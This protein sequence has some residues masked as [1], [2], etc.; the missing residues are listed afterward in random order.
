[1]SNPLE[2]EF[3]GGKV[4]PGEDPPQALVREIRE[5]LG[6]EI[7]V[8]EWLGVSRIHGA[9]QEGVE[10]SIELTV[11]TATLV[12]GEIRLAEHLAH[13]WFRWDEVDALQWS[14]ADRPLLTDLKHLLIEQSS[15]ESYRGER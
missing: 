12:A 1:M 10:G 2:W 5:E 11:Y 9:A 15:G 14:S 4:E 3:P 8:D 6:V 13:G 7:V